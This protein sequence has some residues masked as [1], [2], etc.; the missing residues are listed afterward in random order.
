[1]H[2]LTKPVAMAP[3]KAMHEPINK[4]DFEKF[5]LVSPEKGLLITKTP[6]KATVSYIASNFVKLS[7]SISDA[8]IVLKM[9][10]VKN[11]QEEVDTGMYLTLPSLP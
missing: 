3:H 1:M 7:L 10:I 9:G 5:D 4:S 6:Q 2:I 8:K 11:I